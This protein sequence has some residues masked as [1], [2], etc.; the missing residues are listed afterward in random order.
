MSLHR[1]G[2]V[3]HQQVNA[4]IILIFLIVQGDHLGTHFSQLLISCKQI[5]SHVSLIKWKARQTNVIM[6]KKVFYCLQGAQYIEHHILFFFCF[7]VLFVCFFI[8]FYF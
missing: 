3:L 5:Y 2:F 8:L 4:T 7:F 6:Q 1:F